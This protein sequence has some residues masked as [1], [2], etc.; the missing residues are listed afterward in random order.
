MIC[1]LSPHSPSFRGLRCP[2]ARHMGPSTVTYSSR[3]PHFVR[4]FN[5]D[6]AAH[7]RDPLPP[8]WSH[9]PCHNSKKKCFSN[10]LRHTLVVLEMH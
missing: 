6:T 4:E 10:A 1:A 8:K 7:T 2:P 3:F 5:H 9:F